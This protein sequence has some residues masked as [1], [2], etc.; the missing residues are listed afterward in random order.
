MKYFLIMLLFVSCNTQSKKREI[1]LEKIK[2]CDVNL[3]KGITMEARFEKDGRYQV[4]FFSKE[5]RGRTYILPNYSYYGCP[6]N[7]LSCLNDATKKK[8]NIFEFATANS[9]DDKARA[10]EFTGKYIEDV[11]SEFLNLGITE[12][13]SSSAIGECVIFYYDKEHFAAYVANVNEVIN[14]NWK[15]KFTKKNKISEHWYS[16]F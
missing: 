8:F 5:L 12:V 10:L 3:L 2:V 7:D 15:I 16:N 13:L 11:L 9:I 1:I 14:E 4:P 6:L